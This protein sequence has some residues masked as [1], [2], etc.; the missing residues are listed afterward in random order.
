MTEDE[1]FMSLALAMGARG[2]GRVWPNPSVGCVIVKA[3]QIVGRGVTQDGGRPHAEVMALT[4]A[5]PRAEGATAYV[6]LEPCA[7]HG[8]TPPCVDALVAAKVARV[9]SALEDPD[10]RVKGRGHRLLA[11]AGISVA[12]GVLASRAKD[13][14][15]GFLLRATEGRPSLTLKLANS[16][17]G[18]IATA[19]G[20]SRWITGTKARRYVHAERLCHDAVL[21]GGGTARSDD[22]DLTVRGFGNVRQPVRVVASRHLNLA[23]DCR[24][25]RSQEKGPVWLVHDGDAAAIS[26]TDKA[27]WDATGVR[28]IEAVSGIGGQLDPRGILTALG[29]QGLTRIFCEGG[30]ALAASFLL[31]GLVDELIGFTAGV[32]LGAEGQPSLGALGI[33]VLSDAPRFELVDCR[34]IGGDVLHRWRRI[35]E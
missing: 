10:P 22:P 3:G 5:G 17:D 30:G 15:L 25:V 31:A 13:Q 33:E 23:K 20:E 35:S 19:T 7:H 12:T 2:M 24:L 28:R 14:H 1:R 4:Q 27:N 9:V 8:R 18:R 29:A 11:D 16:F 21:V 34:P 26:S 32:A 6:T